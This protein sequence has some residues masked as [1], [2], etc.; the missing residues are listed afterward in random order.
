MVSP[1]VPEGVEGDG[2]VSAVCTP[3]STLELADEDV[4]HSTVF[5]TKVAVPSLGGLRCVTGG[6][7]EQYFIGCCDGATDTVFRLI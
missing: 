3:Q 5:S 1:E 6:R 4:S 7:G 2:V